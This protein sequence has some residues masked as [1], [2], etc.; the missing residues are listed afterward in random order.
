[1][2]II[3]GERRSG[4][5]VALIYISATSGQPILTPTVQQAAFVE[6]EARKL[7]VKIPKVQSFSQAVNWAKKGFKDI[8][9]A[10]GIYLSRAAINKRGGYLIDNADELFEQLL[11]E[12]LGAEVAA[13]TI[14]QPVAMK[15]REWEKT[16]DVDRRAQEKD[17]EAG[18]APG[19]WKRGGPTPDCEGFRGCKTCKDPDRG[20]HG[21]CP[22]AWQPEWDEEQKTKT[23]KCSWCGEIVHTARWKKT[24]DEYFLLRCPK[25]ERVTVLPKGPGGNKRE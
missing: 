1:M 20:T 16:D 9:I 6:A 24:T 3:N 11:E 12:K 25:C 5:T 18:L 10:E 21:W 13:I 8:I 4:R 15:E 17:I 23:Y 7:G 2:E 19:F 14:C 22:L